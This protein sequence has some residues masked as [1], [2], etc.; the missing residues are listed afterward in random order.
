MSDTPYSP[1]VVGHRGAC[2][3]APENTLASF[4]KAIALGVDAVE[5]DVHL[6]ASGEPVVIHDETLERTTNGKGFVRDATLE[7]LRLVDAGDG[8]PVPSLGEVL[9]LL[10]RRCRVF[11]E[12]KADE[13]AIPTALLVEHYVLRQGWS[14]DQLVLIAFNHALIQDARRVNPRL[15]TGALFVGTPVTLAQIA[16]EAGALYVLPAVGQLNVRLVE[17]THARGLQLFTW[18]A[19]SFE[20]V[21]KAIA[22]KAD[23][24]MGDYPDRI[25]QRVATIS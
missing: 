12:I 3:H 14:Y 21:E 19:N 24:I 6:C 1:L 10:D 8:E 25:Q 23:G 17:D 7:A 13:A 5:L 18:T 15:H 11:I 16:E 4:H 9:D 22:M 2:G 20:Q